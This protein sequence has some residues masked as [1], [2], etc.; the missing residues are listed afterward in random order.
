MYIHYILFCKKNFL[1]PWNNQS[2][3]VAYRILLE[4]PDELTIHLYRWFTK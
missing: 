3:A 1:T 4:P 2:V